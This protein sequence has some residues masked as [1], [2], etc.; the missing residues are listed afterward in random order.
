MRSIGSRGCWARLRRAPWLRPPGATSTGPA[1]SASRTRPG[2]SIEPRKGL[3]G[4]GH[5]KALGNSEAG[6]STACKTVTALDGAPVQ[7]RW[8]NFANWVGSSRLSAA[9]HRRRCDRQMSTL[10]R[11]PP[12][13]TRRPEAVDPCAGQ[14]CDDRRPSNP[15]ALYRVP[16][17]RAWWPTV[18]APLERGDRP[19]STVG[20]TG[21]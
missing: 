13:R 5:F 10:Q 4:H 8:L 21:V 14:S 18:G 7:G 16:P 15:D 17:D 19:Q 12:R 9:I 1:A 6:S 3:E 2:P 20:G 11:Q